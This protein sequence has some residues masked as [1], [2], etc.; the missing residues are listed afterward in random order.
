MVNYLFT[1]NLKKYQITK[2]SNWNSLLCYE[3]DFGIEN[4]TQYAVTQLKGCELN[5]YQDA[6]V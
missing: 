5:L 1:I 6:V 4:V 3:F 2:I